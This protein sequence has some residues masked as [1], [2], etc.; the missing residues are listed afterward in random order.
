[1][2]ATGVPDLRIQANLLVVATVIRVLAVNLTTP[3]DRVMTVL[4]VAAA[5]YA[6]SRWNDMAFI[7]SKTMPQ[8]ARWI[9][10]GLLAL[11][12]WYELAPVAVGVAWAILGVAL[13]TVGVSLPFVGGWMASQ[14]GSSVGTALMTLHVA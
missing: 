10:S 4:L 14:I 3:A 7:P 1:M 6:I 8:A 9:A 12:A 2:A 13:L 5:I 11:L